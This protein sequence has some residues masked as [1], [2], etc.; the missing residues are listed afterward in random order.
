MFHGTVHSLIHRNAAVVGQYSGG[1]G[2]D[3]EVVVVVAGYGDV[4]HPPGCDLGRPAAGDCIGAA[5][6]DAEAGPVAQRPGLGPVTA[7]PAGGGDPERVVAGGVKER[8]F[9]TGPDLQV[10]E[11]TVSKVLQTAPKPD[12]QWPS[13]SMLLIGFASPKA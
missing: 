13:I 9:V 5:A 6:G 1:D 3:V 12:Q 10:I 4:P 11:V 7:V 8:G 2:V